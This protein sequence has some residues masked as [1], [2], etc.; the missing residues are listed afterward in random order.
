MKE[1][2]RVTSW[3]AKRLKAYDVR[4][5]GNFKKIPDML[6]FDGKYPATHPKGKVW[7]LILK[8]AVYMWNILSSCFC[9]FIQKKRWD[10]DRQ[11]IFAK[12]LKVH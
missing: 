3:A 1:N 8:V 11:N 6:R 10:K 4:K 5:L 2:V 7:H 12:P 9:H